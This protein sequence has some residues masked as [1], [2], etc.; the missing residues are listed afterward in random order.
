VALPLKKGPGKLSGKAKDP[1]KLRHDFWARNRWCAPKF[2][3]WEDGYTHYSYISGY[4]PSR[5]GQM[6]WKALEHLWGNP[7]TK[8]KT[9]SYL[10][11]MKDKM[12][13]DELD[14]V[15]SNLISLH[16]ANEVVGDCTLEN[17]IVSDGRVY[18]IDPGHSRGLKCRELDL[19]KILQSMRGWENVKRPKVFAPREPDHLGMYTRETVA[20]YI[21]HLYRLL[22]HEHPKQCHEWARSEIQLAKENLLHRHRRDPVDEAGGWRPALV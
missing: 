13:A 8:V 2:F 12:P 16:A 6:V 19:A 9:E 22:K 3:V 10:K 11:Y 7:E 15:E 5:I 4:H 20:L 17:I 21:T 1:E 18:F 14:L